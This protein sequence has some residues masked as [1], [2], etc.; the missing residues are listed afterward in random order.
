M[1]FRND[2]RLRDNAVLAQ[3]VDE[4][5]EVIPFYCFDDNF[6][7]GEI[8]GYPKIGALRAQFIRESLIDLQKN[9][10]GLGANL[11]VRQGETATAIKELHE[12]QPF[13]AIFCAQEVT[14]EERQI[15]EQVRSLEI[16]LQ[17][18]WNY[19]LYHL[20]D[21]PFEV[22]HT[23]RIFTPFRKKLEKYSSVRDEIPALQAISTPV[24]L[25]W[26]DVPSLTDLGLEE[27]AQEPRAALSF[28][29]G[30]TAAW[31]RL[32]HYFWDK[33]LLKKYKETRNGLLGAD[34]S[35][36]FSAWLA[37]GCISP[38]SIY[39]QIKKY[40]E[41]VKKNSSTYWLYFELMWRDFF[42]F[43]ALK[44]GDEF[45][46]ISRKA[47]PRFSAKHFEAWRTGQTGQD[48]VDAN[49]RELLHTG[50]M[51]NRGRQNVA[52]YLI[53]DLGQPWY[54]GA[55]WFESQLID[56][57]VCSNYGN[58]TYLAG[59]GNDPSEN[60]WFNVEKQGEYYDAKKEYRK[61]WLE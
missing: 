16:P 51:S 4:A 28:K 49:M 33:N 12:Q 47:T 8:L 54:V 37:Q 58:W 10:Q 3:A 45:F 57:D 35:S 6:Y 50:Y 9:L 25:P 59:I 17:S 15:E 32:E 55:A 19:S 44:N 46:R 7:K 24:N 43:I 11:V 36:K 21:L 39:H 48:F 41:Q 38:V 27:P 60:R 18:F 13:E 1:W 14:Y 40:E 31:Q 53:K 52:S 26:G 29:G 56:Y 42:R 34:Y 20:E 5:D 22:A 30:E 61:H 2:L 23:P